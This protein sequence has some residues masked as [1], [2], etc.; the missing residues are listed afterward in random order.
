MKARC[1]FFCMISAYCMLVHSQVDY[2]PFAKNDKE[3]DIQLGLIPEN[4]YCYT[5]KGDTLIDGENWKKVYTSMFWFKIKNP[6]YAAIRDEGKKV[7]AIAKGSTRPRLLYNFN[8]KVGDRVQCGIES[9]AFCCLLDKGEAP[10]TLLGFPFNAYL[11]VERIDTI[12]ARGKLFR[13]FVLEMNDYFEEPMRMVGNIVWVEGV[14]SGAGPFSPWLPIPTEESK[15]LYIGCEET[16]NY[17]FGYSDF[18]VGFDAVKRG[19]VNG[20]GTVDVADIATVISIMAG[21]QPE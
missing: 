8:M 17:V 19:D 12:E 14:G 11:K 6:Y 16:G 2:R 7:Y 3:W 5:I 1:L 18:Y 20:D 10:D 21:Q 15:S 9:N 4:S 13:R